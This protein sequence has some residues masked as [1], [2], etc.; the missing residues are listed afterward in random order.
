M[1]ILLIFFHYKL[2]N[3]IWEFMNNRYTWW[4]I[5]LLRLS[6]V[7][8]IKWIKLLW[9]CPKYHSSKIGTLKHKLEMLL[10]YGRMA[11]T[12]ASLVYRVIGLVCEWSTVQIPGEPPWFLHPFYQEV[13]N[14]RELKLNLYRCW[15]EWAV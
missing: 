4:H 2:M 5:S 6:Y 7:C 12:Q 8:C 9:I 14:V 11:A 10:V 1:F 13:R 15:R 3:K